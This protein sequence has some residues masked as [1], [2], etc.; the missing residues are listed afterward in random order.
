VKLIRGHYPDRNIH[1]A[2]RSFINCLKFLCGIAA[3]TLTFDAQLYSQTGMLFGEDHAFYFTAPAG[4]VLDNKSGVG[5]GVHMAFYPAGFT[6][7]NSPVFAYGRS[8]SLMGEIKT[9]EDQVKSTIRDFRDNGSVNY[10][11]RKEKTISLPGGKTAE[12]YFFSGDRWGNFEAVGYILEKKTINFL[13][14]NCRYKKAFDDNIDKFY[15]ILKSYKNAFQEDVPG[16]D[17]KMFRDYVERAELDKN[18]EEGK[19]YESKLTST[20]GKDL[21]RLFRECLSYEKEDSAI[22]NIDAVFIIEPDG[23]IRESYVWPVNSLSNCFKGAAASLEIPPHKLP[24]F[25]WHVSIKINDERGSD[26]T[27]GIK[28][29]HAVVDTSGQSKESRFLQIGNLPPNIFLVRGNYNPYEY[30]RWFKPGSTVTFKIYSEVAGKRR[31]SRKKFEVKAIASDIISVLVKGA[32]DIDKALSPDIE[33]VQGDNSTMILN[34]DTPPWESNDLFDGYLSLNFSDTKLFLDADGISVGKD[35]L[36][37]DGQTVNADS[38]TLTFQYPQVTTTI[39][40][41]YADDIPGGVARYKRE[42]RAGGTSTL[43]EIAVEEFHSLRMSE[44]EYQNPALATRNAIPGSTYLGKR[45]RFFEDE[46]VV[47]MGWQMIAKT[48]KEKDAALLLP[49]INALFDDAK[50]WKER[51][52]EDQGHLIKELS[53]QDWGKLRPFFKQAAQ[54]CQSM[55]DYIATE[56]DFLSK[57]FNEPETIDQTFKQRV[58]D[59]RKNNNPWGEIRNQYI[60]ARNGLKDIILHLFGH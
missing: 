17:E 26:K 3:L 8:A 35:A 49:K 42:I 28:Q 13:V 53:E 11:G 29:N 18:T 47:E 1:A 48:L 21:G 9:I 10:T 25:H 16:Y 46:Q 51:F 2:E 12:I 40:I 27:L 20:Q 44:T 24:I 56:R 4:W 41:W 19:I 36:D 39:T 38:Y 50:R 7:Q 32:F 5:Q 34:A 45:L 52:E 22:G 43:E 14:F 58:E 55:L 23:R 37:I 59:F 60:I 33:F 6:Y 57:L 31:L 54:F 30:W 15:E